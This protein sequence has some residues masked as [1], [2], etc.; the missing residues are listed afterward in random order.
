MED[1]A[2]LLGAL[3]FTNSTRRKTELLLNYLRDT[4]DPCRGWAV[5][6]ISG[7]LSF[8]LFKRALIKELISERVDPVL[9][10]MSYDYV[11][12]LSETV[13]HLWPT[14]SVGQ[15]GMPALSS[16]INDFQQGDRERVRARLVELLD[17]FNQGQ[18][19][20]LL[21]LGTGGLRVGVSSRFMKNVL[22]EYGAIEVTEIEALWHAIKP[23]YRELFDYLDG[24]SEKPDIAHRITFH[25]VMLS[26]PLAAQQLE[27]LVVEDYCAEWKY[28]G[29]RVQLVSKPQGCAL[30]SRTGDDIG[31]S[32]PELLEN[33]PFHAVLDGELLVRSGDN[34]ASFNQLQQRLNKKKPSTQLMSTHPCLVMAYDLIELNGERLT[35]LPLAIRQQRLSDL[36]GSI[37]DARF[38]LS[39]V[40]EFSSIEQLSELR[41]GI[42]EGQHNHI[43]GLMLKRLDSVYIS[44]RPM[45]QWFKWKRDPLT[46]DAIMMYAQRGHGSRS[47]Y[48][49][50]YTFG[51]WHGDELLPVGKAYSGFTDE[52][53]KRLDRWVRTHSIGRF[54]PVKEVEKTLVVELAFDSV[55]YSSRHKSGIAMRFPRVHRIRWDKPAKEA[56]TLANLR[57]LV[58]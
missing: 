53:L 54:G 55:H 38:Q 48:Y 2:E 42:T 19:W 50:D 29:I 18:R 23:P 25:P 21:K 37:E 57:Q 28:D 47:S 7:E 5:A 32:F 46:I 34:I 31:Q 33:L 6:A 40:L 26:H 30:F 22:A 14:T 41:V 35:S 49:S 36:F 16:V 44:G 8:N 24:H 43:E 20:A 3:Y 11:G 9:F 45:N 58:R 39:P 10:A 56:D 13:A 17:Q 52:E 51:C 12:E 4:P 27:K 15:T 1:F